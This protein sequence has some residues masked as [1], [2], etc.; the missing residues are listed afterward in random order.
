MSDYT[1][2]KF[3]ERTRTSCCKQCFDTLG[4]HHAL[5]CKT[6]LLQAEVSLLKRIHIFTKNG[7]LCGSLYAY[8][9][10]SERQ[11]HKVLNP[12]LLVVTKAGNRPVVTKAGNRTTTIGRRGSSSTGIGLYDGWMTHR[13]DEIERRSGSVPDPAARWRDPVGTHFVEL[14]R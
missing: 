6:N 4:E 13:L 12:G 8:S 7:Y 14:H 9:D 5:S 11:L 3:A 1:S 10:C 2:E